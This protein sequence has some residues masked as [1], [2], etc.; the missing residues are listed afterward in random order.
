MWRICLQNIV[1]PF[2]ELYRYTRVGKNVS[3]LPPL[4]KELADETALRLAIQGD[5]SYGYDIVAHCS[6]VT[7]DVSLQGNKSIKLADTAPSSGQTLLFNNKLSTS[8]GWEPY[9]TGVQA[10]LAVFVEKNDN[11]IKIF[12][13]Q[14]R[15]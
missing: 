2:P 1:K 8:T 4:T 7:D 13:P 5:G 14:T 3:S 15:K 10:T 12:V 11:S 9:N 6:I